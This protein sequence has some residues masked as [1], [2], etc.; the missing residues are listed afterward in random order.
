MPNIPK[1]GPTAKKRCQSVGARSMPSEYFSIAAWQTQRMQG[2]INTE[3]LWTRKVNPWTAAPGTS[4][5]QLLQPTDLKCQRKMLQAS[6]CCRGKGDKSNTLKALGSSLS[7]PE[8]L[9]SACLQQICKCQSFG[10]R[11]KLCPCPPALP[12]KARSPPVVVPAAE[13]S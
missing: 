11:G 4:T 1:S 2:A 12:C 8:A 13:F 10:E 5:M 7:G 6:L 9:A 3:T